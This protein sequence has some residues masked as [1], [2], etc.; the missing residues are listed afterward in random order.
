V[1]RRVARPYAAALFAV[2]EREDV[3]ALRTVEAELAALAEVFR[4]EPRLLRAFEVPS[5]TLATKRTLLAAICDALELRG[6]A[7]RLLAALAQHLRLRYT[8]DVVA[9][10]RDLVDRRE[11]IMRG[12]VEFP[13]GPT[14]AQVE[15]LAAAL[16]RL[17]GSHIELEPEVR[18]ELLAGFVVRVGSLVFDGSL[19]SQLR[20]FA[21]AAARE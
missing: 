21:A 7:R 19:R 12:R 17:L 9:E 5:V 6:P 16:Q 10:F 8:A 18:R 20:R 14:S 15:S 4:R 11:G 13:V 3:P 1:S 2:L